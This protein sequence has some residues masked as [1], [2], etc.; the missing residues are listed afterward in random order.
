MKFMVTFGQRYRNERHPYDR[1]I[2]PDGWVELTAPSMKEARF[3][4]RSFFREHYSSIYPASDFDPSFY[5][6]GCLFRLN[7]KGKGGRDA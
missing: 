6:K 2:T 5:P 7:G 3:I 1:R 4:V